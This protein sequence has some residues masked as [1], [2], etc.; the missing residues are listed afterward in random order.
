MHLIH[1]QHLWKCILHKHSTS[2]LLKVD[3][4]FS[5]SPEP[6]KAAVVKFKSLQTV[7]LEALLVSSQKELGGMV[8]RR[9][10]EILRENLETVRDNARLNSLALPRAGDWL[11]VVPSPALGLQLRGRE[12]RTSV[13]YIQAGGPCL[14]Q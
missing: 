10:L 13:L 5:I 11:N 8:D 6:P 3:H 9:K 2:Q 12:F 4:Q 14:P 7:P 1:N